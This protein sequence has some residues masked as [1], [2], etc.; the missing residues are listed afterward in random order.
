M[1]RPR[2]EIT[3]VLIDDA[4]KLA[5]R[6][7][8]KEQIAHCLGF[9]YETLRQKEKEF[10]AFSASIKK[11]KSKGVADI[12]NALYESA[13]AGSIPAQIF[14]LKN[15]DP[16]NWRDKPEPSFDEDSQPSGIEVVVV[17]GRKKN[18]DGN[19]VRYRFGDVPSED[20]A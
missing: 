11:G 9:S 15:R 7:L 4:E 18:K 19:P 20:A 5:A 13:M 14:F 6:G 17:D 2:I 1:G 16:Q 3:E 10:S 12:A 8:T